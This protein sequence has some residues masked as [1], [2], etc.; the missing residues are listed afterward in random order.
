MGH[1][2]PNVQRQEERKKGKQTNFPKIS[3]M[4]KTGE[5]MALTTCDPHKGGIEGHGTKNCP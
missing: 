3:T 4:H 5:N 2:W 1:L